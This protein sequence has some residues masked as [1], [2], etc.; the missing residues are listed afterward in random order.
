MRSIRFFL[1]TGLLLLLFS[2]TVLAAEAV[3]GPLRIAVLPVQD[4]SGW[5]ERSAAEQLQ[6]RLER[7]V[8]VP[9]NGALQAVVYVPEFESQTAL[10]SLQQEPGKARLQDRMKLLAD[11]LS[12]DLV[13]CLVVT[14]AYE[15]YYTNWEGDLCIHGYAGQKLIGYDRRNDRVLNEGD[16][17]WVNDTY[18]SSGSTADLLLQ[19]LDDIL[20]RLKLRRAIYP[21]PAV[22]QLPSEKSPAAGTGAT[23]GSTK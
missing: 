22:T 18:S 14:D 16:S 17:R 23:A 3:R 2:S 12:A 9:L 11:K 13:V 20:Q 10:E 19:G 6:D 15:R 1:L 4:Q 7:E 5:L 8:H 21:L